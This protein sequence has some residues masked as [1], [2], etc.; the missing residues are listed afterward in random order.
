MER[1]IHNY[2]GCGTQGSAY[3]AQLSITDISKIGSGARSRD[4]DGNGSGTESGSG[5]GDGIRQKLKLLLPKWGFSVTTEKYPGGQ[6]LTVRLMTGPVIALPD[7]EKQDCGLNEYNLNRETR[8]SK[9]CIDACKIALE[10]VKTYNYNDSD[11][12]ID[13]FNTNFYLHLSIGRWDK[14]YCVTA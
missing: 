4:G 10:I 8:V 7:Q 12:Q 13:Y 3:N 2:T 5:Y 6:S 11:S 14:P 1:L 9:P